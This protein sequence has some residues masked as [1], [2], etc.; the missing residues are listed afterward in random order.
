[1]KC[2]FDKERLALLLLDSTSQQEKQEIESHVGGCADCQMELKIQ[3]KMWNLMGEVPKPAAPD[4]M[5]VAFNNML[6]DFKT[7]TNQN[8]KSLPGFIE[9][10]RNWFQLQPRP[11]FAYSIVLLVIGLIAGMLLR[12]TAKQTTVAYN[13]QIDSLSAQVTEMKQLM[14]LSLLE[15]PSASQRIQAVG[16]TD[17]MET[18]N[19]KVTDAL[20]TTLNDDPNINVRLMTLEALAKLAHDPVVREGLVKSITMQDSPL[21]Q[22]A[23]ADVMVKLQEKKSVQSL[24]QLLNKKDL[25]EMVRLKIEQ[26]I[27]KLI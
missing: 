8:N 11:H 4:S 26:S 10:I 9:S 17:E 15:N 1:M 3:K 25:N 2:S 23:I 6:T 16:Y 19:K 12:Q 13:K 14:M 21:L 27:H 5:R 7:Q 24:K 22:S 18:I 20:L